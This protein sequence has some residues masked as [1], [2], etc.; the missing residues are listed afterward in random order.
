MS[1]LHL[2]KNKD[3]PSIHQYLSKAN[4]IRPFRILYHI[5]KYIRHRNFH[6][7]NFL[8]LGTPQVRDT[9][10]CL[11][12]KSRHLKSLRCMNIQI[13]REYFHMLSTQSQYLKRVV[14]RNF[15]KKRTC[16]LNHEKRQTCAKSSKI[17]KCR[18]FHS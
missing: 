4:L 18:K 9:H 12:K 16:M 2:R 15:S 10:L 7:L 17:L 1:N 8:K 3:F 14:I 13:R 6:K 11:S 5:P